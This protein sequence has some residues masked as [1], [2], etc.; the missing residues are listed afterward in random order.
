MFFSVW[1]F[2]DLSIVPYRYIACKN[3]YFN[4]IFT[5]SKNITTINIIV[6]IPKY[7]YSVANWNF[8][9]FRIFHFDHIIKMRPEKLIGL[10]SMRLGTSVRPKNFEGDY[11]EKGAQYEK[12][13]CDL[14]VLIS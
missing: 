8:I 3:V 14:N 13:Q 7:L 4:Y 1:N 2:R 9:S 6:K 11:E 12:T 5:N 10:N